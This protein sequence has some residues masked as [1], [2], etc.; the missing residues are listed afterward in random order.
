MAIADSKP[1]ALTNGINSFPV[2]VA[3]MRQINGFILNT[4]KLVYLPLWSSGNRG[5]PN[6]EMQGFKPDSTTIESSYW[7]SVRRPAPSFYGQVATAP[8]IV[9]L[10]QH[11]WRGTFLAVAT[12]VAPRWRRTGYQTKALDL[13]HQSATRDWRRGAIKAFRLA[14]L[15]AAPLNFVKFNG[16]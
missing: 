10:S 2:N 16:S 11:A 3:Y 5:G 4:T 9:E 8:C 14:T 1:W 15:A 7:S 13:L 12:A 6:F